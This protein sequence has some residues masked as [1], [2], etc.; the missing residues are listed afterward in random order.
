VDDDSIWQSVN[1][2]DIAA[3]CGTTGTYYHSS[4]RNKNSIGIEMCC[5]AGNYKI[6]NKAIE[7]AAQLVAALCKYFDISDVDKYI[8]RHYDITRKHCP[9]PMVGSNNASWTAF[10]DRVKK[11]INPES[12]PQDNIVIGAG[13]KLSLSNVA[14]YGS[15]SAKTKSGSRSGTYYVWSAP[16]INNRVRITNSADR[17][18]K[19]GQVTGWIDV[20]DAK[21]A[22]SAE[23]D[24]S[25]SYKVKVAVGSLN[26][27]SGPSTSYKINGKITDKGVYTIVENKGDWGKLKSGSGWIYLKG[28]TKK[29]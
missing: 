13:D 3:H 17:V 16:V 11:L 25:K 21:K 26:I 24:A 19:S 5:T 23:V 1:L 7:N 20:D 28:Y 2:N 12:K 18:G 22:L 4:C 8:V 15:S 6:G 9:G 27:R 10:K 14:I 29:V